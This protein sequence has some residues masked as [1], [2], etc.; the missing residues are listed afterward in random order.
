MGKLESICTDLCNCLVCCLTDLRVLAVHCVIEGGDNAFV[1][2][3]LEI[4]QRCQTF[5]CV[6]LFKCAQQQIGGGPTARDTHFLFARKGNHPGC[7]RRCGKWARH[8]RIQILHLFE[9]LV[10]Q[11]PNCPLVIL[12]LHPLQGFH[13]PGLPDARQSM[14]HCA[15]HKD[16]RQCC[17]V[18]EHG[19]SF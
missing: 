17:A 15:A 12:D 11:V 5:L 6:S 2:H 1:C 13:C 8:A 10:G 14:H 7:L 16:I 4:G 3:A 19:M 18:L 9:I